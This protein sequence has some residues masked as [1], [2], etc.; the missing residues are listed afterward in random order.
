[1]E[2]NVSKEIALLV[3]GAVIGV[4]PWLLD[5][6]G[7]ELP[8]PMYRVLL[9]ISVLLIWWALARLRWIDRIPGIDTIKISLAN[10]LLSAVA[11]ILLW[12]SI[13]PTFVQA[14][15]NVGS[16]KTELRLQFPGGPRPPTSIRMDNIYRWYAMWSPSAAISL[17]DA[18]STQFGQTMVIP[19][20]WNLFVVFDKPTKASQVTV[21]F[22]SPGF[23]QYEV[24]E[25]T[26]RS[27]I[28]NI[29][30]S[31]PMGYLEIYVMP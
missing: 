1:M 10:A 4:V 8:K 9:V 12:L 20:N 31:I 3:L 28:I 14:T 21:S 2:E 26:E 11:L 15:D 24:K 25:V 30:G 27:V 17:A 7:I 6:M 16:V 22:S 23:P 19:E 29:S 18:G 5:K 13:K